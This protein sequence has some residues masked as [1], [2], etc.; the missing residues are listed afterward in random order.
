MEKGKIQGNKEKRRIKENLN[1][2]KKV[3]KV[4]KEKMQARKTIH[5]RKRRLRI[6]VEK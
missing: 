5:E 2:T 4:N 6:N 3:R 1:D